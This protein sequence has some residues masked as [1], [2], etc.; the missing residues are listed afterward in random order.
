MF[1]SS[2]FCSAATSFH[3]YPRGQGNSVCFLN[4]E[5]MYSQT[6]QAM[7]FDPTS[8]QHLAATSGGACIRIANNGPAKFPPE[9]VIS[10]IITFTTFSQFW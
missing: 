2:A 4:V 3:I 7:C 8:S 10:F 5:R 9:H 6:T 1:S